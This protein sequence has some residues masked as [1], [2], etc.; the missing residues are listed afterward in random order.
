M[1]FYSPTFAADR[2]RATRFMIAYLRGV[3]DYHDAFFGT[4]AGRAEAVRS[5]RGED[6]DRSSPRSYDLMAMPSLDPNGAI[7]VQSMIED[8][9][10]YLA[11]GCEQQPIDVVGTVDTSFVEAA[12]ARIGPL[13]TRA[14]RSRRS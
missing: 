1:I 14:R 11:K 13:L 10:Y 6:D 4:R 9:D 8:Q 7:N 12:L 5:T 2:D 3:R